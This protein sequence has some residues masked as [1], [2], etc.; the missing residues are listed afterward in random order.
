MGNKHTNVSREELYKQ[1]WAEPIVKLAASYNVSGSYLA[2]MCR[3]LRVPTP[4]RG[5]WAKLKANKNPPKEK[6]PSHCTGDPTM[7]IRST[8]SSRAIDVMPV[9]PESHQEIPPCRRSR[10]LQDPLLDSKE[11]LTKAKT[12]S[13][14]IYVRPRQYRWVDLLTSKEHLEDSITL[15]QKL[16]SRLE[17]YGYRISIANAEDNFI[18][19][20]IETDEVP[21]KKIN[22]Y[23]R[24]IPRRPMYNTVAYLGTVAVGIAIVEM[25]ELVTVKENYFYSTP[26]TKKA[27]SRRYRISAYSPY[28]NTELEKSWQDTKALKLTQRLDEIIHEMEAMANLIPSL[29]TEGEKN[30]AEAKEKFDAEQR[31]YQRKRSIEAMKEAEDDSRNDLENMILQWAKLKNQKEYFAEIISALDKE[32][33]EVKNNLSA[34]LSI[35]QTLLGGKSAVDLIRAW[36]TPEER[37]KSPPSWNLSEDF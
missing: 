23:Y 17:D 36:K 14:S 22:E 29:I 25:T 1:V 16:F 4:S 32:E 5:Y 33:I 37:Y 35:A 18:M 27:A 7:W 31:E 6:L 13:S 24:S 30:A 8:T 12:D 2:R 15:A 10:P 28:R 9:P 20:S 34:R 11:I 26:Y 21:E 19:K 3:V